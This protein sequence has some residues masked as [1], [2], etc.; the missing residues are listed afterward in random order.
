MRSLIMVR[1]ALGIKVMI[2]GVPLI[3]FLYLSGY[4]NVA[5]SE[6]GPVLK[7]TL[8]HHLTCSEQTGGWWD[9]SLQK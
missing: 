4:K 7:S 6:F 3:T 9:R 8:A 1:L 5:A 2:L